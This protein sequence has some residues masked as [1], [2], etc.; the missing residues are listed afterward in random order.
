MR[1][2]EEAEGRKWE[3]RF[4]SRVDSDDEFERLAKPQGEE[5][6]EESTSGIWRFDE[7]KYRRARRPYHGDLTPWGE[8]VERVE[9]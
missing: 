9:R 8:R 1:K 6:Q 4:F 2:E 3:P 5:L 7:E